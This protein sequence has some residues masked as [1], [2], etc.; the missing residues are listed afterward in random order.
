MIVT[1]DMDGHDFASLRSTSIGYK[2]ML[3]PTLNETAVE[4]L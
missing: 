2:Q 3:S 1:N 4:S